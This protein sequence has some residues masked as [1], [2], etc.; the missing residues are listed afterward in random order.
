MTDSAA[1]VNFSPAP[2]SVEVR[3]FAK[4]VI[5]ADDVLVEV[6]AVGV[7]GSDLHQWTASHS[8]PVNYPVVLGHEFAGTI[9]ETGDSVRNWSEGD[10][11]CQRNG[12]GDR[13]GQSRCRDEDFTTLI[14]HERDSA[15]A[16]T[17]R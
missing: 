4:P 13:S 2:G 8:W 12:G 6:A 1:V 17:V 11:V 7:C 10:R 16:S 3:P 15:T 9:V 5:G 14:R